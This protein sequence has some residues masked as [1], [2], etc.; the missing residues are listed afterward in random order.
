MGVPT[1]GRWWGDGGYK[2]SIWSD[3]HENP[4]EM[5]EKNWG[6]AVVTDDER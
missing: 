2:P 1:A 4:I 5:N 6:G 3:F